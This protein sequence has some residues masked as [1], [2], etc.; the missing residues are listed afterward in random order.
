[1]RERSVDGGSNRKR[2]EPL[3][4]VGISYILQ[5]RTTSLGPSRP[6]KSLTMR[7]SVSI[8]MDLARQYFEL[9]SL[10]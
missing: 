7:N 6:C 3:S 9:D 1:M 10:V 5:C 4:G 8:G 2:N